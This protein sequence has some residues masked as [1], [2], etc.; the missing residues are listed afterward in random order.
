MFC[1]TR[2]RA[3]ESV[4]LC[5]RSMTILHI[6]RDFT[7]VCN[8]SLYC[9]LL[10]CDQ[11]SHAVSSPSEYEL[12]LWTA[13]TSVVCTHCP[14]SCPCCTVFRLCIT[15]CESVVCVCI[16]DQ[17]NLSNSALHGEWKIA[18]LRLAAACWILEAFGISDLN[19]L[20]NGDSMK[21]LYSASTWC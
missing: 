2:S 1:E 10:G 12:R 15:S 18:L 14:Q 3:Q 16:E 17:G 11:P 5:V 13:V 7:A 19:V 8:E 21:H 20:E 4:P 6:N 9:L